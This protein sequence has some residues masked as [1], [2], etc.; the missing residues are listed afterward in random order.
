MSKRTDHRI[1]LNC[2]LAAT[3]VVGTLL[4]LEGGLRIVNRFTRFLDAYDLKRITGAY[5]A[6]PYLN[7]TIKPDCD[8]LVPPQQGADI[9]G[10]HLRANALG[11]RFDAKRF[12]VK[13][14][15]VFRIAVVGDSQVEGFFAE[16]HTLSSL[17][18]RD[19]SAAPRRV[20]VMNFGVS[21]HSTII[22]YV[23]LKRYVLAYRPDLV[24]LHFD[25]TDVYDD[26]VRYRE[27]TVWDDAGDP[28][29]VKP[30][31]YYTNLFFNLNGKTFSVVDYGRQRASLKPIYDPTRLRLWLLD[32]SALFTYVYA[33]THSG[34]E[35]LALYLR[36][37]E[38]LYPGISSLQRVD[39]IASLLQWCAFHDTPELRKQM[40]FTF[41]ML[42]RTCQL[43]KR[44]HVP[45]VVISIPNLAHLGEDNREPLW[46][47]DA[48]EHIASF[49]RE[50]NIPFHCPLS[51]FDAEVRQGRTIY[52][53]DGMHNNP[54]GMRIWSR[55][56][57]AYLLGRGLVR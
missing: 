8:T 50:R 38:P 10:Y 7:H 46:S 2:L 26:N 35:V 53:S 41:S 11:F 36:E 25:L 4:L 30:S 28:D 55:S 31:L 47:R 49:C 5:A 34:Q 45:V 21:S 18:E 17:L 37:L 48:I 57:A 27:L 42:E 20:E 23:K 54:A 52:Y 29:Y 14:P 6:H 9:P 1:A 32:H 24:L 33:R 19:L 44:H 39:T 15:G 12:A 40:Q 51:E 16:E 43:L 3:A 56:L 22:N 13:A